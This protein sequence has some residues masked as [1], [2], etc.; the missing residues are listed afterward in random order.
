M[1]R[2]AVFQTLV[3]WNGLSLSVSEMLLYLFLPLCLSLCML[4]SD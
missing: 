2:L 3:L 1:K 4:V